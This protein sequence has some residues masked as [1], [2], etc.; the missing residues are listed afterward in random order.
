MRGEGLK[1]YGKIEVSPDSIYFSGEVVPVGYSVDQEIIIRNKGSDNLII[2]K[3]K[4]SDDDNFILDPNY[5][6]NKPCGSL[7]PV[8][9]PHDYCTIHLIF[10]PVEEVRS[11]KCDDDGENCEWK[12]AAYIKIESNDIDDYEPYIPIFADSQGIEDKRF[13]YV[14]P[15]I[16]DF[17]FTDVG[18]ESKPIEIRLENQNEADITL[19]KI[20]N[21][22]LDH[23][24][25]DLNGGSK[26]CGTFPVTIKK[27][28]YCTITAVFKPTSEGFKED[29]F[30]IKGKHPYSIKE[31]VVLTGR[32]T[33][34]ESYIQIV[35]RYID[36]EEIYIK[37]LS[38]IKTVT[39]RNVG[40]RDLVINNISEHSDY[41]HMKL[42]D[43]DKP[44]GNTFPITLAPNDYCTFSVA[45]E[46]DTEERETATIKVDSNDPYSSE[47]Y[48][49]VT[50]I[51][52]LPSYIGGCSFINLGN[53]LPV[54]LLIPIIVAFRRYIRKKF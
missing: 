39:I 16:Y 34:D 41:V 17:E 49:T 28:D 54:Y 38:G 32:T 15:K 47:Y 42:D 6:L 51:G 26:P 21:K 53:N 11:H 24:K 29:S 48:I 20:S 5:G 33:K 18:K 45:F 4:L 23:F 37:T 30:T 35:P 43:G 22:D 10:R 13:L 46:A 7:H 27:G 50:G 2:E 36:F 52:V 9:K 44:C 14:E 3:I 40:T 31:K 19:D 8:I 25:L 12:R 1:V